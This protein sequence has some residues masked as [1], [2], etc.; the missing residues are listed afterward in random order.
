MS[1]KRWISRLA[2]ASVALAATGTA[3]VATAEIASAHNHTYGATCSAFSVSLT[4]Y[5]ASGNTVKI[6]IDGTTTVNQGFSG[7]YTNSFPWTAW[8]SHTWALD[9]HSGDGNTAYD[10]HDSG[11]STPCLATP[12]SASTTVASCLNGATS[13]AD[14]YTITPGTHVTYGVKVNGTSVT[15]VTGSAQ[16]V[17]PGDHVVVTAT[18]DS[19]YFFTGGATS[20]TVLDKTFDSPVCGAAAPGSAATTAATCTGGSASGLDTY[21][22]TPGSHVT[23]TVTVNGSPVTAVL[24]SAQTVSPGDH[25]VIVATADSGY[26]LGGAST[27]TILDKTFTT[28][29]C[30]PATAGTPTYTTATCGEGGTVVGADTYTIPASPHVVWTVLVNGASAPAT[31]GSHSVNPGDT[32]VISAAPAAGYTFGGESPGGMTF[33]EQDFTSPVCL[34]ATPVSPTVTDESCTGPGTHALGAITL[35]AAAPGVAGWVVTHNGSVVPNDSLGALAAGDYVATAQLAPGYSFGNHQSVFP[36]TIGSAGNCLVT[37]QPAAPT[38]TAE[39]CTGPG[40]HDN[41]AIDLGAA[42][43]GVSGFTIVGGSVDTSGTTGSVS[44][45]AGTYTVTAIA[46]PG[47]TFGENQSVFQLTV[48]SAGECLVTVQPVAPTATAES[49]TGPG[50]HQNGAIDLGAAQTGISGF[51]IVG[52]SVDTSGTTGTVSVPAG[53]YT[54]SAV[55]LPGYAFGENQSVFTVT[56]ASAGD[57]LQTAA[58]VAPTVSQYSCTKTATVAT[59]HPATYTLTD[60]TGVQ[61]F[62]NGAETATAAGTYD[63]TAGELTVLASAL[64]GYSLPGGVATQTFTFTIDKAPTCVLGTKIVKPVKKPRKPVT[65]PSVLPMTGSSSIGLTVVALE[66]LVAGVALVGI[67]RR[68]RSTI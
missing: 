32:V 28:P 65:Q 13:G 45:P 56:V 34:A 57:C 58:L 18:A 20:H 22:I 38:A 64:P 33:P 43:T 39:S 2:T 21:T 23:Y 12:G 37:V 16:T 3:M 5:P 48:P 1:F 40:T 52:G 8:Q 63:T 41:G 24:G 27:Q 17:Q 67:G 66:L 10:V 9:V 62:V 53:T 35:P 47:Y 50:T 68:R 25:V 60:V 30:L 7:S 26:T 4:N 61:W 44:V 14:T 29:V 19:G 55:A 42:Q 36:L 59:L 11:T 51:T 6:V 15:P 54:V 46:A 31:A 49:C